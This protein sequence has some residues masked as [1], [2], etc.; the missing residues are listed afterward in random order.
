MRA[1]GGGGRGEGGARGR[2]GRR[3]NGADGGERARQGS[4]GDGTHEHTTRRR[5]ANRLYAKGVV[6]GYRRSKVRQYNHT[7]LLQIEGVTSKESA[8]FYLGKKV[9][10]VYKAKT[11]KRGTNFRCMWGKVTQPHGQS[12]VVRAKFLKNLPPKALGARVRV[13]LYPNRDPTM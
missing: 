6:M 9:A 3:S 4:E 1:D 7:S 10:Y 2:R 8:A 11:K 5:N 12:G 13:M